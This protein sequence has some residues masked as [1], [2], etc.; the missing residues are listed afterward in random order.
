MIVKAQDTVLTLSGSGIIKTNEGEKAF[1]AYPARSVL[2]A[3]ANAFAH[4]NYWIDG[5]QIQI[6][7]FHDRMEISS[8]GSLMDAQFQRRNKDISHIRPRHRNK[9]IADMLMLLGLVQGLGTGF[10]KIVDDYHG[11]DDLHRPFVDSDENG[12]VL[13][14]PDLTY[15]KGVLEHNEII[16]EIRVSSIEIS[17]SEEKVLAFC[18]YSR[19]TTKDI[20]AY[21][22]ISVSTYLSK[23]LSK[24][25]ENDLLIQTD[26]SPKAF[27][28]N[29]EYVKVY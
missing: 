12:F 9:V 22:G 24:L 8:P 23:L 28:A 3:V 27:M 4:R 20:A 19:H 25:V 15:G 7:I 5:S 13:T 26:K 1:S 16:P 17:D 10:G 14:L 11:A 18:Y 21:L 6:S 2:E 29:R